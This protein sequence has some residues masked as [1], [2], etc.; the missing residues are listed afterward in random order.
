MSAPT[1]A[2]PHTRLPPSDM[3]TRAANMMDAVYTR[4]AAPCDK[5]QLK[6]SIGDPTFDGNLVTLDSATAA[7]ASHTHT[8]TVFG[9]QR[10]WGTPPACEAVAA[11]WAEHFAGGDDADADTATVAAC[12][13]QCKAENVVLA[14]GASEALLLALTALCNA[15]DTVLLPTPGFGQYKFICDLYGIKYRFYALKPN[16]R[17]ECDLDEIKGLVDD[18]T[19]ALLITNPSNPC[20]SSFSKAHLADIIALAA[21][22][23]VPIVSDEIYAGMVYEGESFTSVAAFGSAVPRFVIGGTAKYF[24][25]PGWR[26]GWSMLVDRDGHAASITEA[27]HNIGMMSLGANALVQKAL[28]EIL[29]TCG[30]AFL[31]R[32]MTEIEGNARYFVAALEKCPGLSCQQPQGALYIMVK[33]DLDAFDG[34]ADDVQFYKALE[35]EEN[36]QVIPGTYLFSPGFFRVC[37]T[38]PILVIQQ[39]MPRLAD[40]CQRHQKSKN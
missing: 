34:F 5:T 13:A 23:K 20:G 2:A 11:Y 25:A 31:R 28:P 24:M 22:L 26:L 1:A 30:P 7:L 36:V 10:A 19:R 40:F 35:D 15:G 37:I 6:L 4:T 21:E 17:W 3:V 27:M 38:R 32:N 39:V 14:C 9:Y 33:I 29:S 8:P 16:D 18:S 12:K